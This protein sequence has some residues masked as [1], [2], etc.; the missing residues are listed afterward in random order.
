[1]EIFHFKLWYGKKMTVHI[2]VK[3][4]LPDVIVVCS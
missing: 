2:S 3:Y 4:V 1:M